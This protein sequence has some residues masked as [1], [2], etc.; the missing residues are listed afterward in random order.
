MKGN[1]ATLS[2]PFGAIFLRVEVILTSLA[3]QNFAILGDF[4]A[5]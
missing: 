5:L 2:A 3:R 1:I 4:E